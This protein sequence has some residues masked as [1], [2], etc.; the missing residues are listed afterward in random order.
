MQSH[1]RVILLVEAAAAYGRGCLRGIAKYGRIHGRWV[2][3]HG[4]RYLTDR[5]DLKR[6]KDF[7]ADGI[8]ARIENRRLA[9]AVRAMN[10]PTV[11]LR[12]SFRFPGVPV[13][14]TDPVRVVETAVEHLRDNGFEHL[15]FCG[16]RGLDFSDER[17][18][19]FEEMALPANCVKH[20]FR[21]PRRGH[22]EAVKAHEQFRVS[23]QRSLA[24]WL[25]R[26]PKPAGIL[27][28]NDTRGRQVLEAC[29][30]SGI[31]VPYDVAVLGVDNDDVVCELSNPTLSS[32]TP[33]VETIGYKAAETLDRM[34][35]GKPA[36]QEVTW[37]APLGIQ[38]R[39]SSGTAALRDPVLLD[40]V[41]FIHENVANGINVEDVVRQVS[42]SRSTLERRFKD[43]LGCTPHDFILRYRIGRVRQLLLETALS[44]SRIAR[45][46]GFKTAAHMTALFR[47]RTGQTPNQFRLRKGS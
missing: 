13:I 29:A 47:L 6:L 16:Y 41:Q 39:A 35:A 1:P 17:R 37:V 44:A 22:R 25:K 7:K 28:C 10:L 2:F 9:T 46:T 11:D 27:A 20:V 43:R 8:I 4:M 14:E 23:D 26:L 33:N 45:Q 40:A 38:V 32:V 30:M 15:A 31:R 24:M 18:R 36:P 5:L 19:V 21:L 42:I 34:M 3:F 12:G